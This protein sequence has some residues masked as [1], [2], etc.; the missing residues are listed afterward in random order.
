MVD[1]VPIRVFKNN[2]AAGV[3]YPDRKAMGVYSSLWNG[4]SWAT[5]GGL[6][7]ID[8]THAPFVASYRNFSVQSMAESM[9]EEVRGVSSEQWKK[10]QWV[11]KNFII[12]N[13]CNDKQRYPLPP[14]ECRRPSILV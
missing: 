7:K 5:Q 11:K 10:L 6:V 12:Y 14:P 8:W 3:P 4:D 1:D 2:K 9:G 13:Y